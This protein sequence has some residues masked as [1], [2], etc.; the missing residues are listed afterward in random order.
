MT[1]SEMAQL[2]RTFGVSKRG[3]PACPYWNE[4]GTIG[5]KAAREIAEE[6]EGKKD[7]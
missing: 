5:C 6:L 3:C 4:C 7:G 2:L 1:K